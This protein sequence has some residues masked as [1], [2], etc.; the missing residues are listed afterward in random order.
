MQ[1]PNSLDQ[2]EEEE[3]AGEEE[4]ATG[5]CWLRVRATFHFISLQSNACVLNCM[6][7]WQQ[8][9]QVQQQLLLLWLIACAA[10]AVSPAG[11]WKKLNQNSL[12]SHVAPVQPAAQ[13]QVN[14]AA[15]VANCCCCWLLA[16]LLPLPL[17]L[18]LAFCACCCC[19]PARLRI[20]LR[21]LIGLP[22][23]ELMPRMTRYVVGLVAFVS[24]KKRGRDRG[25]GGIREERG[26]MRRHI[27]LFY[28]T[29]RVREERKRARTIHKSWPA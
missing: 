19:N 15:C 14:S 20:E 10:V 16:A 24:C 28:G 21:R 17:L 9:Q 7:E 6:I 25:V 5:E 8:Q 4:A 1:N 29:A 23:A 27:K 26:E 2:Q 13:P 18:L 22:M 12:I 11:K 3:E